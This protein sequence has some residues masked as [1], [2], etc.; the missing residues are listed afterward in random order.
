MYDAETGKMIANRTN[1]EFDKPV[2]NVTYPAWWA[3]S[4][5]GPAYKNID[6]TYTGV[7]FYEGKLSMPVL[8]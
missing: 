2:Y 1:N 5:M 3:Y 7:N 6:A 8:I 4:G